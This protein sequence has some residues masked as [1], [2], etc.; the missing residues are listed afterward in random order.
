MA[1]CQNCGNEVE[2]EVSPEQQA[3]RE[4]VE[5]AR[6]NADRDI[7]IARLQ[8]RQQREELETVETVAETQADAEVESAAVEAEVI[9]AAIEAAV[10]DEP[11]PIIINDVPAEEPE[12]DM[13]PPESDHEEHYDTRK[14]VGMG[15][16]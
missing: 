6:I 13:A 14:R 9:G 4:Q 1:Y 5:I 2:H 12:D 15:L 16:W 10:V 7:A 8:A 3:L 11:E